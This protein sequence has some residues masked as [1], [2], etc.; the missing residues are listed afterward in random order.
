MKTTKPCPEC[1]G[2]DILCMFCNPYVAEVTLTRRGHSTRR[3]K[4]ED[5]RSEV[6]NLKPDGSMARPTFVIETRGT[7]WPTFVIET[8]GTISMVTDDSS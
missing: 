3:W 7:T 6:R 4:L 5:V 8:R 2:D 1:G